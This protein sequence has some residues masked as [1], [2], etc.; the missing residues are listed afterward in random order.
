MPETHVRLVVGSVSS[1]SC[2]VS[3]DGRAAV[4]AA[5]APRTVRRTMSAA[6]SRRPPRDHDVVTKPSTRQAVAAAPAAG[7][8]QTRSGVRVAPLESPSSRLAGLAR[9]AGSRRC[10]ARARR[11]RR[12]SDPPCRELRAVGSL[13]R[14]SRRRPKS[15]IE[16]AVFRSEPS[17]C[18]RP[19]PTWALAATSTLR[20]GAGTHPP[21]ASRD[22]CRIR[23]RHPGPVR[24]PPRRRAR[25]A[26]APPALAAGGPKP[27]E[28]DFPGDR[29]AARSQPIGEAAQ[30][31]MRW[32][33]VHAKRSRLMPS[34]MSPGCSDVC[35]PDRASA[36]G[37]VAVERRDAQ[38]HQLDILPTQNKRRHR[39]A[40]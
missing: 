32:R 3:R 21:A 31:R 11:G 39:A 23:C 13:T 36:G 5:P 22:A 24:R 27:A 40:A 35:R 6:R 1:L 34:A 20:P 37:L 2:A 25:A 16:V 10:A 8:A 33:D 18:P 38:L 9:S 30:L 12:R 15:P 28:M 14:N 26:E 4:R 29:K 17:S 19:G 7:L